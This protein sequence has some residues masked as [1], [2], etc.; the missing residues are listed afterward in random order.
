MIRLLVGLVFLALATMDC[1]ADH[2]PD[3]LQARGRPETVL[4][5]INLETTSIEKIIKLYGKP[6]EEK[7]WE[8][9]MPNSAGQIDYYWRRRG[10][11]LHVQIEFIDKDPSWK[12][13]ELVEVSVGTSRSVGVT[14]AGLALGDTLADLRRVYGRR[15]HLRSIPKHNIHDVTVQ[16]RREEYSL[17][18]TLDSKNRI[19]SLSL[20]TP[21]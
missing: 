6:T 13:V 4:A 20:S 15:F 21:E 11:N 9:G 19:T 2:L 8:P 12:P 10:L 17:V 18:A 5:R 3:H 16:W 14:R 7:K 1:F